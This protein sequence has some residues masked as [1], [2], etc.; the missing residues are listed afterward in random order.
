[1]P[2]FSQLGSLDVLPL[3]IEVIRRV[4]DGYIFDTTRTELA[5]SHFVEALEDWKKQ[6]DSV[7]K[8]EHSASGAGCDS[9]YFQLLREVQFLKNLDRV[10]V[11]SYM[12]NNCWAGNGNYAGVFFLW[13]ST[14][15]NWRTFGMITKGILLGILTMSTMVPIEMTSGAHVEM[16]MIRKESPRVLYHNFAGS[17]TDPTKR[18]NIR[19][20][21]FKVVGEL[22]N[23]H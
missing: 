22:D 16:I 21:F 19:K 17:D 23:K 10:D 14:Q 13:G 11:E 3:Q 15:S 6:N 20:Y 9:Q 1:M 7:L 8:I 5:R 2:D 12:G 18:K 4:G